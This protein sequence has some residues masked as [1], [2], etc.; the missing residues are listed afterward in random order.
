MK[1]V[2]VILVLA[3]F[4][5]SH[6][7]AQQT[8]PSQAIIGFYNLENLFDTEDDPIINDQEFLPEGGNKWTPERY[9]IKLN[10]M[11]KVIATF[12]PD[13]LG[14]SEIENRKVLEDLVLHPNIR[15]NRYQIVQF[16]MNDARGVDVAFLYKPSVFKPFSF[17]RF[18][19]YDP[20]EPDFRTRDI[21]W[22]KGLFLGDTLHVVVNHWPSRLGGKDDKRVIA[23][24]TLRKAVDSV[25][26]INPAANIVIMGDFND[27]PNNRSIKKFLMASDDES[28]KNT[29]INASEPTFKKGYG[30]LAYNGV[31]NL[32][33]QI[34]ISQGLADGAN[35]EY[36]PNS[37]MVVAHRW[38]QVSSG[39][40]AG[41]PMRTF[42]GGVFNPEGFSDH[43]PV[44]IRVQRITP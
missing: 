15:D 8:P 18:R 26:A 35:L 28:K 16:D 24:Q 2:V 34:I 41:M 38:M 3:T 12:R 30:T 11:S 9:Q 39:K 36:T 20:Q 6:L 10:N 44:F 42:R 43:F 32:F 27:D 13:I 14:V 4:A 7:K 37:F 40:Y 22:V 17:K 5:F 19:V 31:W 21:L 33:D 25:Q 1:K 23:G 29:L